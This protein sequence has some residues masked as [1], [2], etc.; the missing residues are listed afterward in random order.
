MQM[1][2]QVTNITDQKYRK[3]WIY[4]LLNESNIGLVKII[5]RTVNYIDFV[6]YML[7]AGL[8]ACSKTDI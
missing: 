3:L 5:R 6:V 1:H 4:M 8:T 2:N 7:Q